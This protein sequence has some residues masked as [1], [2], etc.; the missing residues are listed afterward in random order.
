M[1]HPQQVQDRGVIV[2]HM[3]R[4]L[5]IVAPYWSVSP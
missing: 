5:T 1:I 4:I 3:Y 2:M